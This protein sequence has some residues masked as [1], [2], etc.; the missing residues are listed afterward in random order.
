MPS[1]GLI[2]PP[3]VMGKPQSRL[4]FKSQFQ[5]IWG[6]YL[7]YKD[8]IL[9]IAIWFVIRF[10]IFAIWQFWKLFESRQVFLLTD[11]KWNAWIIETLTA[12]GFT[13]HVTCRLTAKNRDQFRNPTLD[14]R[15]CAIFLHTSIH[16]TFANTDNWLR[17]IWW[18]IFSY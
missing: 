3:S 2:T 5:H 16:F 18:L 4:G 11:A 6:F 15:V 8:A 14:N 17:C 12:A 1:T 7:N 10:E 13:T 9:N